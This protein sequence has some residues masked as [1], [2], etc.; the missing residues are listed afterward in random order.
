VRKPE[1]DEVLRQALEEVLE[2]MF[3]FDPVGEAE[4]AG[5]T[6]APIEAE[7]D[8]EGSPSGSLSVR[9]AR[10]SATSMAA[11]FLAEDAECLTPRQVE[12]VVC[13]LANM[14]CGAALSR[15]E[16]GIRLEA[17][18]IVPEADRPPQPIDGHWLEIGNGAISVWLEF[19]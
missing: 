7:V 15:L 11:D 10:R 8:F 13:E 16:A 1:L 4:P 3:F 5:E 2:R 6:D 9:I 17:P 12:D 19:K 14:V 18:R